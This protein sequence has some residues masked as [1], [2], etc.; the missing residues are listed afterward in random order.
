MQEAVAADFGGGQFHGLEPKA[1]KIAGMVEFDPVRIHPFE[2]P[3]GG[4][5][6]NMDKFVVVEVSVAHD[7]YPVVGFRQ[8]GKC[9]G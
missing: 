4:R 8:W 5:M 7:Q 2:E 9:R 6:Q 3:M 1:S